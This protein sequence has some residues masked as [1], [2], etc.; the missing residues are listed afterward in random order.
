HCDTGANAQED[1][2]A[3]NGLHTRKLDLQE[4]LTHD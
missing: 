2:R 1:T 4:K 3:S